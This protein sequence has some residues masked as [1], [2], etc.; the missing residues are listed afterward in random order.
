[1]SER[2]TQTSSLSVSML[3]CVQTEMLWKC[4]TQPPASQM[5]VISRR[6][7]QMLWSI[8]EPGRRN[9]SLFKQMWQ[10]YPKWSKT[11]RPCQ[12][13][14][15]SDWAGDSWSNEDSREACLPLHG[16][17]TENPVG[18][19]P[20]MS[21]AGTESPGKLCRTK[22]S[23]IIIIIFCTY[24]AFAM[25]QVLYAHLSLTMVPWNWNYY[26]HHLTDETKLSRRKWEKRPPSQG[27][28]CR[29]QDL[30]PAV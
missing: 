21:Q 3:W 4:T 17:Q 30:T 2:Q 28:K 29:R 16:L 8:Q 26:H 23:S 6:M 22:A 5:A 7:G 13:F 9:P 14:W 19:K 1:M 15:F 24:L 25:C 12:P 27:S 18:E 20:R 11:Y 10:P